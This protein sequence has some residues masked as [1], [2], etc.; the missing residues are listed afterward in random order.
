[1]YFQLDHILTNV[2]SNEREKQ[3]FPHMYV[4]VYMYLYWVINNRNKSLYMY[5]AEKCI[6]V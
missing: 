4:H 6:M 5:R 3:S 1:M 2:V